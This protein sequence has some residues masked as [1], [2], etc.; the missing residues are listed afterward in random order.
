VFDEGVSIGQMFYMIAYQGWRPVLPPDCPSGYAEL[1]T[2]CWADEPEQ[3]PT[4][5]Q[6]LKRLQQLYTEEKQRM[7]AVQAA[8]LAAAGA[9]AAAAAAVLS[10]VEV[11]T[12]D[13][14]DSEGSESNARQYRVA[15]SAATQAMAN[16]RASEQGFVDAA[17]CT[18]RHAQPGSAGSGSSASAGRGRGSSESSGGS[19]DAEASYQHFA[20]AVLQRKR[21]GSLPVGAGTGSG[22]G[23]RASAGGGGRTS[24]GWQQLLW[25]QQQQGV[26]QQI[27]EQRAAAS[28]HAQAQQDVELRTPPGRGAGRPAGGPDSSGSGNLPGNSEIQAY[29]DGNSGSLF[30]ESLFVNASSESNAQFGGGSSSE[31]YSPAVSQRAQQQQL[32]HAEQ[33]QMQQEGVTGDIEMRG[34]RMSVDRPLLG[35]PP[36]ARAS[37]SFKDSF[38][39]GTLPSVM[40]DSSSAKGSYSTLGGF[41]STG[42]HGLDSFRLDSSSSGVPVIHT[43][44]GSSGGGVPTP[45][46]APALP[47]PTVSSNSFSLSTLQPVREGSGSG[48]GS[49]SLDEGVR[50][51]APAGARQPPPAPGSSAASDTAGPREQQA[52][53]SPFAA[54]AQRAGSLFVL[55]KATIP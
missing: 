27:R 51:T 39:T 13:F 23:S 16:V 45:A 9:A 43:A 2:E 19:V 31:G 12:R 42:L 11:S 35:R 46:G 40:G 15:A 10:N 26:Q 50:A 8:Q 48:A 28:A 37:S 22:R 53:P 44:G 32:A 34:S 1:M 20:A 18:V 21:S 7:A 3:R 4:A 41:S 36:A 55:L 38:S 30:Q 54:L 47:R 25:Q 6:L 14:R 52:R 17:S 5:H 33:Q 29:D 49:S 24:A